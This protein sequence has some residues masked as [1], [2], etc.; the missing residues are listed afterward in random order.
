[1][2][3]IFHPDFA[4]A[5][6]ATV[7]KTKSAPKALWGIG[8]HFPSPVGDLYFSSGK[9]FTSDGEEYQDLITN[10]GEISSLTDRR[11]PTR[12]DV[13]TASAE[14]NNLPDAITQRRFSRYF[15][16]SLESTIVDVS[17][18]FDLAGTGI[19]A[20]GERFFRGVVQIQ[21]DADYRTASV[22][23]LSLVQ[24]YLS[25]QALRI[26]TDEDFPWIRSDVNGKGVPIIFGK[27][28]RAPGRVVKEKSWTTP[29]PDYANETAGSL[30]AIEVGPNARTEDIT[31]EF[32]TPTHFMVHG[33]Y[34]GL[35]GTGDLDDVEGDDF[36]YP[37]L[38][39]NQ[40][41]GL[42]IPLASWGGVQS[43]G[44]IFRFSI[45]VDTITSVNTRIESEVIFSESPS[46]TPIM[47]LQQLYWGDYPIYSGYSIRQEVGS[48]SLSTR[49][50][51]SSNA[52]T[53]GREFR[54]PILDLLS[55]FNPIDFPATSPDAW[56]DQGEY[57][58]LQTYVKA[59][60]SDKES[61]PSGT[62]SIKVEAK[63][64]PEPANP[65][66]LSF[67]DFPADQSNTVDAG[68]HRWAV[69]YVTAF[70]ETA[71][72]A[73]T[74][75]FNVNRGFMNPPSSEPQIAHHANDGN[76]FLSPD[77]SA[78][79]W[80]Y[81]FV[82][83]HGETTPSPARSLQ[84]LDM[85]GEEYGMSVR[86]ILPQ[87]DAL[88]EDCKYIKIYRTFF[89]G[90]IGAFSQLNESGSYHQIGLVAASTEYFVDNHGNELYPIGPSTLPTENTTGGPSIVKLTN[91][92]VPLIDN[93]NPIIKKRIYRTSTGNNGGWK[94]VGEIAWDDT[95]FTDYHKD[96]IVDNGLVGDTGDD[97][98][99]S[100]SRSSPP[101]L[102][103]DENLT[104][105][106]SNKVKGLIYVQL[107]KPPASIVDISKIRVY[108]SK[109]DRG[110]T[111]YFLREF[112]YTPTAEPIDF[113]DNVNDSDLTGDVLEDQ[114]LAPAGSAESVAE[115]VLSAHAMRIT[116]LK[117]LLAK[118]LGLEIK[119][120]GAPE[121]DVQISV[122]SNSKDQPSGN[123]I[124]S[125]S[126]LEAEIDSAP[127]FLRER[128]EPTIIP[129]GIVWF[130]VDTPNSD[131]ENYYELS[132]AGSGPSGSTR[133]ANSRNEN[134][135]IEQSGS[136]V[137]SIDGAE[138]LLD[139][140]TADE[141]GALVAMAK[142]DVEIPSSVVVSCDAQGIRDDSEGT[143]TGTP[144]SLVTVPSHVIH[145]LA[146]VIGEVSID[147]IDVG[148][149]GSFE[150]TTALYDLA[151]ISGPA[152]YR[153]NGVAQVTQTLQELMMQL[154][155]EYRSTID[156]SFDKL[157]WK[158]IPVAGDAIPDDVYKTIFKGDIVLDGQ[159]ADSKPALKIERLGIEN[160]VN[161]IDL[162][163]AR[164]AWIESGEEAYAR[165][166]SDQDDDSVEL[167]KRLTREDLFNFDFV[168]DEPTALALV[169]FYLA[170][171]AKPE[172]L[173]VTVT[174]CASF[175]DV[176]K[177]D[178]LAF[179]V[180]F[181]VYGE[182]TFGDFPTVYGGEDDM[183]DDLVPASIF[184]VE[185][186]KIKPDDLTVEFTLREL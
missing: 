7:D 152:L 166:T 104:G 137:F 5:L 52:A 161:A 41:F 56:L 144:N 33:S 174:L 108:R 16:P 55:I 135:W 134:K 80:V 27:V 64:R 42:K 163:W 50:G 173:K 6:A 35:I 90:P 145:W 109:R 76:L 57:E 26:L 44:N 12:L 159:Q 142:L 18:F 10:L 17:L 164:R 180:G 183:F 45:N 93:A 43:P 184:Q 141:T 151:S 24:K 58:Y 149:D 117:P 143:F 112:S 96:L 114:E 111:H 156:W 21:G 22:T 38:T 106:A 131:A 136:L 48:G 168:A 146:Q 185:G 71:I 77:E 115:D 49:V 88:P 69:T 54:A 46:D 70:G 110:G 19:E 160:V 103:L 171:L 113:V 119:K 157:Q 82:N 107:P 167:Y 25:A 127:R 158:W 3:R 175:L 72:G 36:V 98:A 53:N 51:E 118:S 79:S 39:T 154:G 59:G 34:H 176:E 66:E 123:T 85:A 150:R 181:S 83:D 182:G 81:T 92:P 178:L 101:I 91:I 169:Q 23:I 148:I 100:D 13:G 165:T 155:K 99:P 97:L 15:T 84:V 9:V 30:G 124:A 116:I 95:T 162:R 11:E 128:I 65:P 132:L 186:K 122:V 31:I 94:L 121:G 138:F 73:E 147:D 87:G 63:E 75:E 40:N 140:Q 61:S 4:E 125:V 20:L 133:Y 126:I 102:S 2:P 177:D 37:S 172:K 62:A 14:F 67:S 105:D 1:M 89:L 153:V 47:S 32:T 68:F 29:K 170:R 86:V 60:D 78:L 179:D 8:F 129:P 120:I 74:Q 139:E 28:R 130:K